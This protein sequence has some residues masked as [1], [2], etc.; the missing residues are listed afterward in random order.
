MLVPM[1]GLFDSVFR[2]DLFRKYGVQMLVPK[3]RI[4]FI[5]TEGVGMNPPFQAVYVCWNLLPKAFCFEEDIVRE[6]NKLCY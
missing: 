3:G 1:N 4:K 2:F 6:E 5:T